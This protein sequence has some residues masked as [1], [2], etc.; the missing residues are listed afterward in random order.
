MTPFVA[1]GGIGEGVDGGTAV[2]S[3]ERE[4]REERKRRSVW[5]KRVEHERRKGCWERCGIRERF[6]YQALPSLLRQTVTY[7]CTGGVAHPF[8]DGQHPASGVCIGARM[9]AS[10]L[11]AGLKVE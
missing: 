2:R 3:R 9:V 6:I 4:E 8:Y 1:V 7:Q 11:N 5:E 10:G